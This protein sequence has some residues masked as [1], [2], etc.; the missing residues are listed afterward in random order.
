MVAEDS[1]PIRPP[2]I[3]SRIAALAAGLLIF[4]WLASA[5]SSVT[6]TSFL[7]CLAVVLLGAGTIMAVLTV[8]GVKALEGRESFRRFNL[9]SLMLVC[10]PLGIYLAGVRALLS[11]IAQDEIPLWGWALFGVLALLAMAAMTVLLTAMAEAILWAARLPLT[12]RTTERD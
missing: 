5:A 11:N 8:F 1:P 2:S 12:R 7:L 10:V 3:R 6:E 9:S 4:L